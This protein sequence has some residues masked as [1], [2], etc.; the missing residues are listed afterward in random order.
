MLAIGGI[1]NFR[2]YLK[3]LLSL[4]SMDDLPIT[5]GIFLNK[6]KWLV[7]ALI[8]SV[9][10]NCALIATFSFFALKKNHVALFEG[11]ATSYKKKIQ[12]I[13]ETI[14]E[15]LKHYFSQP[16]DILIQELKDKTFVEEGQRR[17]D[18]ALAALVALYHFDLEKALSSAPV[19]KRD[20]ALVLDGKSVRFPLFVDLSKN[21]YHSITAFA[22]AEVYPF[23]PE[24]IFKMLTKEFPN[25]KKDLE[26]AFFHSSTFHFIE[27]ALFRAGFKGPKKEILKLLLYAEWGEIVSFANEV[28]V[29]LDGKFENL[30]Q[31]LEYFLEKGEPLA[32]QLLIELDKEYAIKRLSDAQFETVL[33]LAV[34]TSGEARSFFEAASSSLRAKRLREKAAETL[35]SLKHHEKEKTSN[36]QPRRH[37]VKYGDSLWKIALHYQ[38]SLQAIQEVNCLESSALYPGQTLIIPE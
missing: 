5:D 35:S 23:T 1:F 6:S 38:V 33:S 17:C 9:T 13:S 21:A 19:E 20:I 18:L 32:A 16:P 11:G 27:R 37:V 24:G 15:K 3:F 12:P 34:P 4:K 2:K 30:G 7:H 26:Q 36:P 31:F 14:N 22:D 28:R 10:L 29:S 25:H 8:L